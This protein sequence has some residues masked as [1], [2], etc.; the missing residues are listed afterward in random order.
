[1]AICRRNSNKKLFIYEEK[2]SKLTL[3]N[4]NEVKSTSIIVDGC[5]INDHTIRCDFMHV[6]KNF[7]RYIVLK[8]QD[9]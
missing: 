1:M 6:A 7:E 5:E 3:E 4:T 8:G 2:R 9:L